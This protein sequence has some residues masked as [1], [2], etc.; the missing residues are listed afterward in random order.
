MTD[1]PIA[2]GFGIKSADQVYVVN[3][4]ADA[5][6]VGSALVDT[7]K[8]NLDANGLPTA[9]LCDNVVEFVTNL[10]RGTART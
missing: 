10:A 5:A 3:E 7:I 1:L 9:E 4:F 6:V 8:A 2:V